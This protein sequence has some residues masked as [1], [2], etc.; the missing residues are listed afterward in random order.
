[1]TVINSLAAIH[2]EAQKVQS[3]SPN[4]LNASVRP[5]RAIAEV[6]S[7]IEAAAT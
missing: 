1:M 4:S 3:P 5:V 7:V 2:L 6:Q